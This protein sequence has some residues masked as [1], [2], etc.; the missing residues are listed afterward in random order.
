M[1][2]QQLKIENQLER[3]IVYEQPLNERV[4][5]FLRLELLFNKINHHITGQSTLDTRITLD[6]V[7]E[8][9]DL[10]SRNDLKNDIMKDLERHAQVLNRLR[11]QPE[12]DTDRLQFI[13]NQLYPIIEELHSSI[14]KIGQKAKKNS[15]LS[16]LKQRSSIP[17]GSCAFD[18]PAFHYWL[19]RP[20]Q[21]RDSAIRE[22]LQEFRSVEKAV[23][24]TLKLIRE[25]SSPVIETAHKGFF[26]KNLD[27]GRP[28]QLLRVSLSPEEDYYPEISA[29]RH[30][31]TIRFLYPDF[32]R[33]LQV[34]KDIEFHLTY[35]C[36]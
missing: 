1:E 10:F 17:G 36:I 21:D 32:S 8:L 6:S 25:S 31:F 2:L 7:L 9:V 15:F 20:K 14:G 35:C 16:S 33:T 19:T 27:S 12:V 4:R 22:W 5:I 3:S 11:E 29:G 34:E 30:R 26:Q 24:L 13:L 23:Q 28:C 18:L